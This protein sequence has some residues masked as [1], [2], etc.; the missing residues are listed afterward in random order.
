MVPTVN[1]SNFYLSV[2]SNPFVVGNGEVLEEMRL[3]FLPTGMS[4]PDSKQDYGNPFLSFA[5]G[6]E[7]RFQIWT[8]VFQGPYS[9]SNL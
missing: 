2:V 5:M 7:K 4:F 6:G 9:L 8:G 1:H 3:I